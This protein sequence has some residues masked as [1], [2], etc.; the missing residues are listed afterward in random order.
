MDQQQQHTLIRRKDYAPPAYR[1]EQ[2]R[3]EIDLGAEATEVSAWLDVQR[4]ATAAPGQA[5]ML[6]GV[7][8]ELLAVAV[9]GR[10]LSSDEY[11]VDQRGLV[12]PAL[13]QS[14][15]V[16]TRVMIH[17][18]RNSALEGLYQSGEFLLTQCEAEGFRKITY[19][20]D[21]PDVMAPFRVTLRGDRQRYPV[22][23]S[24]GNPIDAGDLDD[25]RHYATWEDPF[26]KPCY[27]F[28]LVAGDLD[29]I[30]DHYTTVSGRQVRLRIYMEADNKQR[31][32]HAMESLIRAMRWDEQRFGLEYDL[33][34]YNI[35]VTNDFNM[36]AMENKG[37][38]VFNAKYVLADQETATDWDYQA[39][40]GVIGH[41]YFHNWTGN[42]VTC[43][44]WFQLTLKEGLTVFRDQEFS[45]D[46]HHRAV[47][48][49][50]DVRDL[51][52]RQFPEDA[53]P[54]AH[55]V[56]PDQYLEISNF[57][58]ATVYQKGAEVVRM[59]QTLLGADHFTAGLKLY[60]QRH[61]G[62]AATCDD[63]LRAMAETAGRDLSQFGRWYEQAGTPVISVSM[64]YDSS[65]Q[66]CTLHFTQS[67]P[68]TL[69]S[70]PLMIPM[71]MGLLDSAGQALPLQLDGENADQAP[72]TRVLEITEKCQSFR[73]VN[74]P[75][76]PLPS[77]LRE[78]SA[79]VKID[80]PWERHE[81][82]IIMRHDSDPFSRWNAAETLYLDTLIGLCREYAD[83]QSTAQID[84]LV[85]EA[86]LQVLNDTDQEPAFTAELLSLPSENYLAEQLPV[87]AVEAVH[88]AHGQ[89]RRM[90]SQ[91]AGDTLRQRYHEL[92][93]LQWSLSA[94]ATG[95]RRLKNLCLGLLCAM[96][97]S[98][99]LALAQTQYENASCMTDRIAALKVLVHED[100]PGAGEAL[101]HFASH[102]RDNPLVMDKWFTL[103]AMRP[104]AHTV[105]DILR[106]MEHPAYSRRN[107]NKVRALL[108]A[109][110]MHNP[111]G[112]HTPDGTGYALIAEEVL[113]LDK[114]NPQT[115]SRLA[116]SFNRWRHLDEHRSA[117]MHDWLQRIASARQL[118]PDVYEV[119]NNALQAPPMQQR[120][121]RYRLQV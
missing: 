26:P 17:P 1:I 60:L 46:M 48:R 110:A 35:V 25:G 22:L 85:S 120:E 114:L 3:L 53:G 119:I 36:G 6:D 15:Q 39:I 121:E 116:L 30:E 56:R 51:R 21:R 19:Y 18:A 4:T 42:R 73:F 82:A 7:G 109:F 112:F 83:G 102:Y 111:M 106:L 105:N 66:I 12:I 77:L 92:H 9:D 11:H 52:Q 88:A 107:P 81:L 23:L 108:G 20:L 10:E 70:P 63:F 95:R 71:A 59:Y 75:R 28:A 5:L 32:Q 89:L 57:Y 68:G 16:H 8:L 78:Y 62:E 34:I 27:L 96:R 98:A 40:E 79:P 94:E 103:Q 115:A 14:A 69:E 64:D 90:L 33:D 44:D 101:A 55:P 41:E 80:Y 31:C 65:A 37:L 67:L 118:S 2:T 58:T 43:R 38:N 29:W 104:D 100:A 91:S 54:M 99:D 45:A 24:N 93:D 87:V 86:Y 50:A 61:D 117:L 113:A 97:D 49:I 74:I 72:L 47:K 13:P 84:P 76:P